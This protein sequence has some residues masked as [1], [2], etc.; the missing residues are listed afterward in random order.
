MLL[1]DLVDGS[2]VPD[3]SEHLLQ[4]RVKSLRDTEELLAHVGLP[5]AKQF[6]EDNPHPRFLVKKNYSKNPNCDLYS[7]FRLWRLLAEA[8]LKKLDLE[9]AEGAFV[10]CAN[11]P[12][13]QLIKRLRTIQNENLQKVIRKLLLIFI[14]IIN[15]YLNLFRQK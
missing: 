15:D 13:L 4:L 10:R 6:I 1:D 2:S 3:N 12:G 8:S 11:Y 14:C 7:C 9:T 5:E